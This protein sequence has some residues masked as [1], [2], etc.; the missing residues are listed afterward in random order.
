MALGSQD[1][2]KNL[3]GTIVLF[4][5]KPFRV[6]ERI[7]VDAYD[8]FVEDIGLRSTRLRL[9]NG[10]LVTLPNN[11]VATTDIENVSS[12]ASIRVDGQIYIPLDTPLEQVEKAASIV[13]E[14]LKDHEGMSPEQPP[15]V[16]FDKFDATAF[17]ITFIY[18]YSPPNYW[19]CCEF[20]QQLNFAIFR[21]FEEHGIQFSLPFRHSFWKF[22]DQQG[23]V[24][25]RMISDG[26]SPQLS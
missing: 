10:H 25:V 14:N 1:T 15:R 5:D 17:R 19:D 2:L 23:P 12:R 13:R 21:E 7:K 11:H 3:F 20:G 9:L 4:G 22:D 16:Y 8:G 6:G 18:W 26:P 24:D